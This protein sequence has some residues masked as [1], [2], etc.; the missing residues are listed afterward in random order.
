MN[1]NCKRI[2]IRFQ[3]DPARWIAV[4]ASLATD[5]SGYKVDVAPVISKVFSLSDDEK[6]ALAAVCGSAARYAYREMGNEFQP[7]RL[8]LVEGTETSINSLGLPI[9]IALV[10]F[11]LEQKSLMAVPLE[12][13][14]IVNG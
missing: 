8:E 13:W 1:S 14:E 10:V 11:A 7:I 12:G 6:T 5:L 4:T 2:E 3:D 9:A